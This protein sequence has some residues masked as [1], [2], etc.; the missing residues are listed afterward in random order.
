MKAFSNLRKLELSLETQG[1]QWN[2]GAKV[3]GVLKIKNAGTDIESLD[4]LKVGIAY[5]DIKKV[6]AKTSGCFKVTSSI[7]LPQSS[8][9][10]NEQLECPF[11]FSLDSNTTV[12][13]KKGSYHLLYGNLDQP[14][15]L[16]IS[17]LPQPLFVELMKLFETFFRFK[18]K[19]YKGTK[20]GVDFILIPPTARE[21]V[22]VETL[23]L[24]PKVAGENLTL[25]YTFH[26][27]KIDLVAAS[28][29]GGNKM[30]KEAKTM[31]QNL[32][33]KDYRMGKTHID[34]DKL[35]KLI[36]SVL[37]EVKIKPLR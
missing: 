12:T 6:H 28:T 36:E 27:K 8:L 20:E 30:T 1:E 21:F 14:F 2:Q 15:H 19:E 4:D 23:T 9:A 33:P 18:Q 10:A 32:T 26:L 24:S 34:Q 29:G 3:S 13:D 11:E 17:I 22:Q 7:N 5:A 35:L 16:Q 25:D 31:S 37:T